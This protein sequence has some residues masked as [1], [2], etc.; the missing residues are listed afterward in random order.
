MNIQAYNVQ[1]PERN[2]DAIDSGRKPRKD[3]LGFDLK[4]DLE[5]STRG[6]ESFTFSRWQ[7]VLYD[8]MVLAA[9][10]EFAD[11]T[12]KRPPRG[13]ARRL[14]LRIPVHHPRRWETPAV[15]DA[16]HDALGF[17]TGDF[18]AITFVK[19]SSMASPPAQEG[20]ELGVPTEAVIA[21]S[22]GMDSRAVAGIMGSSLGDKLVRVRV[23]PNALDHPSHLGKKEPFATVPYKVKSHVSN[24][25]T[26]ARSRG[27][28]FTLISGL[29]AYLAEAEKVLVPESGQGSLGPALVTVNH[30]YPDYRNH[31]LFT[32]R[33]ERFLT[34][35]LG[36][37]VRFEF[38]RIWNTKGETLR[39]FVDLGM[40][41]SWR[42]TRSCWRNSQWVS[43]DKKL[44][45]CGACAACMLRR[46]SVHA[47][48]LT[49]EPDV[50]VCKNMNAAS[51]REAVDPRF[52][53]YNAAFEQYALGGVLHLDDLAA[54]AGNDEQAAV[55][56]HAVLL[57]P[58]MNLNADVVERNLSLLLTRHALEWKNYLNDLGPDSFI[59]KWTRTIQ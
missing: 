24:R 11:R 1:I 49:E 48:G 12:V 54:M 18:W 47:A 51:V 29:A 42:L 37:P 10:V 2:I 13:W 8:A 17:L 59:R 6:L 40:R 7:P 4:K 34:A 39:E 5:F 15:S 46:L 56:R 55:R 22:E 19:R 38:P 52:T 25:E 26:S 9:T 57:A 43:L 32:K 3:H 50:Y 44:R 45:Q 23:S 14:N 36:A 58:A 28:K 21:Y 41:D 20:L 30:A 27:F 53:Q 16:L 33:M 35:L 31:P